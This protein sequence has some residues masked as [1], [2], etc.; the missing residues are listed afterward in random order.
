MNEEDHFETREQELKN[1]VLLKRVG[2][3]DEVANVIVFLA[4]DLASYA[5]GAYYLVDAGMSCL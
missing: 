1:C 3:P 5:T 4:S 2:K